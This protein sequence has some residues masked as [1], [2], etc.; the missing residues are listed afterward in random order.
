MK[1]QLANEDV[2]AII[3]DAGLRHFEVFG[4]MEISEATW[5]R[6][7]RTPLNERDREQILNVVRSISEQRKEV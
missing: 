5:N 2:R 6:L 3:R 4:A 7:I 1:K